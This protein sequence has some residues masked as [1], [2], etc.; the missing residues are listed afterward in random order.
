MRSFIEN[1]FKI[2]ERGSSIFRESI[3]GIVV[4]FAIFYIIPVNINLFT[5]SGMSEDIAFTSIVIVM[6]LT[7]IMMGLITNKPLVMASGA[8]MNAFFI[9]VLTGILE[10]SW[11]EALGAVLA[12][13]IIFFILSMSGLRTK[14]VNSIPKDLKFAISVALG[15]FIAFIGLN[16]GGIIISDP[17][18]LVRLGDL[19]NPVVLLALFG[20]FLVIVLSV[21]PGKINQYAIVIAMFL[22]AGLGL[23]LGTLGV[24]FM[25]K[26]NFETKINFEAT[27]VAFKN[28]K[29]ILEPK[30][31]AVI[32]PI[33]FIQLFDATG[34]VVA[35][36]NE[37]DLTDEA[38]KLIDAK[39]LM[40]GDSFSLLIANTLGG[41]SSIIIAESVI[42]QKNGSKTGF[43]SVVTGT[44]VI[45]TLI[46][47]PLLSVFS[48]IIIDGKSYAPT[49][50]LAL[51]YVGIMLFSNIKKINFNDFIIVVSSFL[52]IIMTV[53]T[54]SLVN[55][56]GIGI[57]AY[58]IM[59][60]VAK[61]KKEINFILYLIA[62]FYIINLVLEILLIR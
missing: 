34:S 54:Y 26:Y 40:F 27:F 57:I 53:F 17:Q 10:F 13:S 8:G 18:T 9:F 32:I 15:L 38:G 61:R 49:T 29:I 35:I 3:A 30:T 33:L 21:L 52:I 55:G 48:P 23:L 11:Q 39:K 24:D 16:M 5:K 50:T 7:C 2:K 56:F 36:G 45:L 19:S 46:L 28:I 60:I 12:S 25:P 42:A 43:A 51:I 14:I 4:F 37:M 1:H 41:V 31:F 44:L 47:F 6:G 58:I 20:V 59:M 62:G 22:T